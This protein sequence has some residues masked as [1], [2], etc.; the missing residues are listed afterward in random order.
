MTIAYSRWILW[1]LFTIVYQLIIITRH[2]LVR[3]SC[4]EL[5]NMIWLGQAKLTW[6]QLHLFIFLPFLGFS[7]NFCPFCIA[8]IW[9]M[10]KRVTVR[11]RFSVLPISDFNS[12]CPCSLI[13]WLQRTPS[14]LTDLIL[15]MRVKSKSNKHLPV[16]PL[17]RWLCRNLIYFCLWSLYCLFV[18][19]TIYIREYHSF[20]SWLIITV[21]QIRSC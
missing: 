4:T 18:C 16:T 10:Y 6:G 8:S 13:E 11:L 17:K 19:L 7:C 21:W 1:F 3:A 5:A 2:T 14:L 15:F 12:G 9:A 20:S